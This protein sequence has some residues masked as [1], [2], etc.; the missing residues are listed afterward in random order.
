MK[1]C[2]WFDEIGYLTKLEILRKFKRKMKDFKEAISS[3]LG[4]G[5]GTFVYSIIGLSSNDHAEDDETHFAVIASDDSLTCFYVTPKAI[6]VVQRIDNVHQGVTCI[7]RMDGRKEDESIVFT[8]GRDGR[9]HCWSRKRKLN[10][11]HGFRT[12]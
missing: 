8:G 4:Y 7:D 11:S 1:H 6:K 3:S 5:E 2:A 10:P 9:L 12:R